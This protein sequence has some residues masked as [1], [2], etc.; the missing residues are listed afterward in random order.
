[1][2]LETTIDGEP[3]GPGGEGVFVIVVTE[4]VV[5]VVVVEGFFCS[6]NPS[7]IRRS[8]HNL[9]CCSQPGQPGCWASCVGEVGSTGE[10]SVFLETSDASGEA[11]VEIRLVSEPDPGS[12]RT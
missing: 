4:V 9:A 12:S 6:V 2:Y 1:M 3:V 11:S 8:R 5:V 10:A 7:D